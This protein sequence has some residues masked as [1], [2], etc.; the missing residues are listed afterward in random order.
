MREIL[1]RNLT[2]EDYKKRDMLITEIV[3]GNGVIVKVERRCKYFV[4]DVFHFE[5]DIDY[6]K[7]I[8][9]KLD[10]S[11]SKRHYF[12]LRKKDDDNGE[13]ILVCKVL[14]TLFAVAKKSIITVSYLHTIKIK[15]SILT[16]KNNS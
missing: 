4:T 12:I 11:P 6:E 9:S 5:Q 10:E 7:I 8:N 15:L 13:D 1:V 14:G 16:A 2:A 3:E